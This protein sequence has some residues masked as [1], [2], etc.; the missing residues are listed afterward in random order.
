M[1]VYGCYTTIPQRINSTSALSSFLR[2][3]FPIKHIYM[4]VPHTFHNHSGEKYDTPNIYHNKL[5][6]LKTPY[7]FGPATKVLGCYKYVPDDSSL[8]VIDDD[9]EYLPDLLE[10]LHSYNSPVVSFNTCSAASLGGICGFEGY[11]IKRNVLDGIENFYNKLPKECFY[12][13]DMWLGLYFNYTKTPIRY[14]RSLK[15][16]V[17]T[18]VQSWKSTLFDIHSLSHKTLSH[19]RKNKICFDLLKK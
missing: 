2:Q 18:R 5:T 3:S 4:S 7:D 11:L 12:V 17:L 14:I 1:S 15:H 10:K 8:L 9:I 13:D 6:I 19:T 16:S